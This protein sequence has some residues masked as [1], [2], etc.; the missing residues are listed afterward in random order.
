MELDLILDDNHSPKLWKEKT[1]ICYIIKR[2]SAGLKNLR[3]WMN[4]I[5]T[6][7]IHIVKLK[8]KFSDREI[9][10]PFTSYEIKLNTRYTL[11]RY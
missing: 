8:T 2:I 1:R 9:D 4:E 5:P 7:L 6:N 10:Y 3:S 11:E